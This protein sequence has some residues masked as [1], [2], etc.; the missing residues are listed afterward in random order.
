MVTGQPAE[1]QARGRPSCM[2]LIAQQSLTAAVHTAV[3]SLNVPREQ[4]TARQIEYI[5]NVFFRKSST[6]LDNKYI[7]ILLLSYPISETG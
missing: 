3:Q 2:S 7:I 1:V 5:T 6:I 4:Y